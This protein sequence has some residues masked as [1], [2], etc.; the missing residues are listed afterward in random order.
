MYVIFRSFEDFRRR[1][2]PWK[3]SANLAM[4]ALQMDIASLVPVHAMKI[5]ET[6]TLSTGVASWNLGG[7]KR[8]E[9]KNKGHDGRRHNAGAQSLSGATGELPGPPGSI[10]PVA[11]VRS[12]NA[13]GLM[14]SG[15]FGPIESGNSEEVRPASTQQV[16]G[17]VKNSRNSSQPEPSSPK[18]SGGEVRRAGSLHSGGNSKAS[19]V[20]SRRNSIS[21]NRAVSKANIT[22]VFKVREQELTAD[23]HDKTPSVKAS[24]RPS[25]KDVPKKGAQSVKSDAPLGSVRETPEASNRF[26]S[27]TSEASDSSEDSDETIE[28]VEVEMASRWLKLSPLNTFITC[29]VSKALGLVPLFDIE[30]DKPT[31]KNCSKHWASRL[32]H[33][34]LA[35]ERLT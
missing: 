11:Q 20:K 35:F 9:K 31:W 29:Y 2:A 19:S 6:A 14:E 23:L 5:P 1:T 24:P 34:N 18:A 15:A 16:E 22:E 10:L 4:Q 21:L 27:V 17:D 26:P 28:E 12:E 7:K 30:S 3:A 33:W 32:Y 13:F 25:A 8:Q